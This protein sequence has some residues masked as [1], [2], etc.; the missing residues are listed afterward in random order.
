MEAGT[1]ME[2]DSDAEIDVS[3]PGRPNPAFDPF[4]LALCKQ[5]S[6]A[7]ETP[8]EVLLLVFNSSYTA[9]K[10]ALENFYV[11]VRKLREWLGSHWC[12]PGYEAWLFEQVARGRYPEIPVAVLGDPLLRGLW[13]DVRHRGDGKISLNPQQ[14][15]KA[16]EIYEA[17]GW[18]TGQDI[19][20]ELTGGD[21]DANVRTRIGEHDRW[22]DGGLPVPNQQGGGSAQAADKP[23][24]GND[25]NRNDDAA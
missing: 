19:T 23:D 2:I 17:H 21:Y 15:A 4:F 6:A 9:S 13:F 18:R 3:S 24:A 7:L 11:L 25:G 1:I 22:T 16:F 5:L 10:A 14:E 12:T 8:V 20:A